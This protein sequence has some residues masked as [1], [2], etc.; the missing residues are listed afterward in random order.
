MNSDLQLRLQSEGPDVLSD[1]E[2]L[3]FLLTRGGSPGRASL[4]TA[5]EILLRLEGLGGL[6]RAGGADLR[7]IRGVGPARADRLLAFVALAARLSSRP[8]VR[9]QRLDSPRRL[10]EALR[11]RVTG[12][13]AE[14][15]FVALLDSRLRFIALREIAR[16]GPS[17]VAVHPRSIF[18]PALREGAAALVLA[19][20]H[21]SGDPTPSD[22][23]ITLTN[24]IAGAAEM[25]GFVVLD[26]VIVGHTTFAS[27]AELGHLDP[28]P[29][30]FSPAR[31]SDASQTD[32]AQ[33]WLPFDTAP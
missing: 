16:G 15:F 5:G 6:G 4:E 13:N 22:D 3:S 20:N 24:R 10:F 23:D 1:A 12:T 30:G 26:H 18:E 17:R 14:R 32:A 28:W 31:G 19:H 11:G 2:L 25:L 8:L 7:G 9:G 29:L 33:P 21:P 27:L